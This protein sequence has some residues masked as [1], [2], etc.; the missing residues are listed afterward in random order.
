MTDQHTAP[1]APEEP[2]PAESSDVAVPELDDLGRELEA[3]RAREA[4]RSRFW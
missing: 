1:A 2:L 4:R 3:A